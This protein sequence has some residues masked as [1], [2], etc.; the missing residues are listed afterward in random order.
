MLDE[1]PCKQRIGS[2]KV[3]EKQLDKGEYDSCKFSDSEWSFG[4]RVFVNIFI[5]KSGLFYSG[6]RANFWFYKKEKYND[7][8]NTKLEKMIDLFSTKIES[9]RME[10]G[11]TVKELCSL[12][13]ISQS[14]YSKYI[15]RKKEHLSISDAVRL[16][17]T[18]PGKL[19]VSKLLRMTGGKQ[20]KLSREFPR[21]V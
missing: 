18:F 12:S 9:F 11:M 8:K 10:Q 2:W 4:V 15:N 1:T 14:Q 5:Y 17:A 13:Q 6:T 20:L 19:T 16:L 7:K 3:E 21:I